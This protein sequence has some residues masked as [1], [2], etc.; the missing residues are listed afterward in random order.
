[1]AED[2]FEYDPEN[3]DKIRGT[4]LP[5]GLC[6][7]HGIEI[8]EWW[9]PRDA[10]AA[11]QNGGFV[12]DVSEEYKKYYLEQKRERDKIARKNRKQRNERK[13]AQ[14]ADPNHNPDRNYVHRN[15]AIAGANK[16][17]PMKAL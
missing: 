2:I 8:Q 13:K 4:R 9:T 17:T 16:N 7:A 5:F 3:E 1:M 12:G 6:K 15:G 11:L 14:L 10:W